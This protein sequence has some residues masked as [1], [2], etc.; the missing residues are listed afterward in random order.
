MYSRGSTAKCPIRVNAFV[1]LKSSLQMYYD[2]YRTRP[3]SDTDVIVFHGAYER[4]N[5]ID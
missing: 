4:P 5:S 3:F 2:R 1:V